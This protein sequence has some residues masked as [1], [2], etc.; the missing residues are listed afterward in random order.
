MLFLFCPFSIYLRFTFTLG[1]AF[2]KTNKK[3]DYANII[4][5]MYAFPY[6]ASVMMDGFVESLVQ[7]LG[8]VH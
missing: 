2:L 3:K 6:F 4:I 8:V 7:K 1:R 5:T